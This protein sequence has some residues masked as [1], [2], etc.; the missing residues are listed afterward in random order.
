VNAGP[1]FPE[2]LSRRRFLQRSAAAGVLLGSGGFLAACGGGS[3]GSDTLKGGTITY[4]YGPLID[5]DL[6]FQRQ[7]A[8]GFKSKPPVKVNISLLD[9][10]NETTQL[11][12]AY[13]GPH[14]PDLLH[15]GDAFMA[16]FAGQGAFHDVT[17]LVNAPDFRPIKDAIPQPYWDALTYKGKTFGV[18]WLTQPYSVLYVNL[19]L[20]KKAGISDFSSSYDAMRQAAKELT[21][22]KVYGYSVPTSFPDY[23]HQELTNYIF[24]AGTQYVAPDGVTGALDT[25]EVVEAMELLR[26]MHVVD[27]S[28]P[29]PGEYDRLGREALFRAGRLAILHDGGNAN[30]ITGLVNGK[31]LPFEWGTFLLPP[32]PKAQTTLMGYESL[33]I[34][35]KS[36]HVADTWA[37]VKYLMGQATI[38]KYLEKEATHMPTQ[39]NISVGSVYPATEK[40]AAVRRFW[41]VFRPKGQTLRAAPKTGEAL[42]VFNLNF[43]KLVSGAMGSE[44]MVKETNQQITKLAAV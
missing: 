33:H 36:S 43:E 4:L 17:D 7:L 9:W 15:A 11:T 38:K 26:Q 23:A 28:T 42:R 6:A 29:R 37:Y 32:G 39:T 18:P 1:D 19:D 34:A 27:K 22:G 14:P 40:Y 8:S 13:A 30:T 2:T 5:N 21:G 41:E 10:S 35:A 44:Q 3:S 31:S 12:T 24:N 25:P 16:F 20:M